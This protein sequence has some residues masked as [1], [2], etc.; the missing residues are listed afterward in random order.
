MVSSPDQ[1]IHGRNPCEDLLVVCSHFNK[2]EQFGAR[3]QN[4]SEGGLQF[5]SQRLLKVGSIV[6]VR[7]TSS[8]SDEQKQRMPSGLRHLSL[9][10]V[11]WCRESETPAD[12]P[13]EVG[14]QFL[15]PTL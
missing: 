11:Q 15:L 12:A 10:R 5:R 9:A 4:Y 1:R 7:F 2:R 8:A 14:V 6:Q 13:Y 3:V